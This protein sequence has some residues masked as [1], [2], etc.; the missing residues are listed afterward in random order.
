M[1]YQLNAGTKKSTYYHYRYTLHSVVYLI[2]TPTN[3]HVCY[4][5]NPKFAL[6]DLKR[7]HMFRS[8]DHPQGAYIVPC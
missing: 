5:I 8:H 2:N 4:L 7:S 3:A 6:K 1:E